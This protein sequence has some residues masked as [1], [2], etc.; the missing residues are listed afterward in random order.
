MKIQYQMTHQVYFIKEPN[1]C[2]KVL[3]L[4]WI[5]I[6]TGVQHPYQAMKKRMTLILVN[7]LTYLIPTVPLL[8]TILAMMNNPYDVA[9]DPLPEEEP[10]IT[11]LGDN[12][13]WNQNCWEEHDIEKEI[14]GLQEHDHHNGPEA[15]VLS[16]DSTSNSVFLKQLQC[17]GY[18]FSVYVQKVI[19]I[20]EK[21]ILS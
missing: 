14:P 13:N 11:Y 6:V 21:S 8:K 5:L 9:K 4:N 15:R 19:N 17:V 20:L 12:W 18:C 10:D 2:R 3:V 1:I 7:Q 16:E